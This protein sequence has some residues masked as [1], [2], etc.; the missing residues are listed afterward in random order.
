MPDKIMWTWQDQLHSSLIQTVEEEKDKNRKKKMTFTQQRLK[1][2]FSLA[3][4]S[5]S[6]PINKQ[7]F[8]M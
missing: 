4:L 8:E 2:Q 3:L 6:C 5:S 1:D 7:V